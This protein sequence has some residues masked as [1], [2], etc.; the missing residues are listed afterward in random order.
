MAAEM[1]MKVNKLVTQINNVPLCQTRAL[2][3]TE[4]KIKDRIEASLPHPWSNSL[5]LTNFN[6]HVINLNR[7]DSALK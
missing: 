6:N 3:G 4:M 7:K 5:S 2:L 1:E